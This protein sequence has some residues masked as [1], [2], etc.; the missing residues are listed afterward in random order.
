VSDKPTPPIS[1]FEPGDIIRCV[2]DCGSPKR[3]TVGNTYTVVPYNPCNKAHACDE[4]DIW[5]WIVDDY[6][7]GGW[8]PHSFELVARPYSS[9]E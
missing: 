2:D 1:P 4:P 6:G 5:V 3:I 7:Y 9:W 8:Y